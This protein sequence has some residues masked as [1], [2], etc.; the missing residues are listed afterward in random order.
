MSISIDIEVYDLIENSR[1][2]L[3]LAIPDQRLPS[4]A[5]KFTLDG[6]SLFLHYPDGRMAELHNLPQS[7]QQKLASAQKLLVGERGQG[8]FRG[9]L[10]RSYEAIRL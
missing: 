5:V 2:E 3:L 1:G 9:Q 8:Q 4:P 10:I 6:A 7:L